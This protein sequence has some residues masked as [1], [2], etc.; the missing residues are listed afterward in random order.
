M[1]IV[2]KTISKVA[3]SKVEDNKCLY[4]LLDFRLPA[5][6]MSLVTLNQGCRK[7]CSRLTSSQILEL[8]ETFLI[9]QIEQRLQ[10]PMEGIEVS[11]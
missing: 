4:F 2:N 9:A 6:H 1:H 8:K 7:N 3:G 11:E 5:D 10:N